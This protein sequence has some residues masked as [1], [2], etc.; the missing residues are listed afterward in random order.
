MKIV[1]QFNLRP[2]RDF[3]LDP[4]FPGYHKEVLVKRDTTAAVFGSASIE[5]VI[6]FTSLKLD[7]VNNVLL[8]TSLYF[9]QLLGIDI[10]YKV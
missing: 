10:Q 2:V 5:S 7:K 4:D 1:L 6:V 3:D 8:I 9:K